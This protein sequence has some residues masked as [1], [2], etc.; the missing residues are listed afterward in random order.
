MYVQMCLHLCT[1]FNA[2]MCHVC[3][4]LCGNS[5]CLLL[6]LNIP[7]S[8]SCEL[9]IFFFRISDS[10]LQCRLAF[11]AISRSECLS[12][13][14]RLSKPPP[15]LS[16]V[17]RQCKTSSSVALEKPCRVQP[18]AFQEAL[19]QIDNSFGKSLKHLSFQSMLGFGRG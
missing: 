4:C 14:L 11:L 2:C 17:T 9:V 19:P 13:L 15:R 6:Q 7:S 5:P 18:D 12:E 3:F 16:V 1:W 8:D 10:A